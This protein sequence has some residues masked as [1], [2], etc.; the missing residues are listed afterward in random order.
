MLYILLYVSYRA[1]SDFATAVDQ[2]CCKYSLYVIC[3]SLHICVVFCSMLKQTDSVKKTDVIIIS[4]LT[5]RGVAR[6][7]I[8][9][10]INCTIS[11]LS[12][13]KETK[14]PHKKFKVD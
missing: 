13:V 1:H 8:W 12:W 14:Q 5:N 7:L 6:N 10:G 3:R 9:V 4:M 2:A 11:N